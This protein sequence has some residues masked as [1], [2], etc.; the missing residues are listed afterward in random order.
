MCALYWIVI[1]T[2][3]ATNADTVNNYISQNG[4]KTNETYSDLTNLL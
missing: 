4:Y 3:D 1:S 2:L